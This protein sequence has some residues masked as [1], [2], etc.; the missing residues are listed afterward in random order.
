VDGAYEI[1]FKTQMS[2]EEYYEINYK[3]C[4]SLKTRR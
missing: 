3:M 1:L 4:N 2:R